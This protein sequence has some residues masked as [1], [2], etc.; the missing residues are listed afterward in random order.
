V[1]FGIMY[2]APETRSQGT[3]R[4]LMQAAIDRVRAMDGVEKINL[5]V[6]TTSIPAR[7]L[8][9]SLGFVPYGI[10][11]RGLKTGGHDYDLEYMSLIL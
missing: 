10:E 2:V 5:C 4:A 9:L 1:T 11:P 7:N 3:G 6:T 8:Y